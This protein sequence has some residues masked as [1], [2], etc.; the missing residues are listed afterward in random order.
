[1]DKFSRYLIAYPTSKQDT[2]AI[3]K[4]KINFVIQHGYLPTRLISD[5]GTAFMSHE[6]EEMAAVPGITLKHATT[7]HAQKNWHART[8]SPANQASI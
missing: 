3:A 8:I 2:K 7:K 6:F 4:V 1:M 5:K